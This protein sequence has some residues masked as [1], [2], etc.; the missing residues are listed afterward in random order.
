MQR[1]RRQAGRDGRGCPYLPRAAALRQVAGESQAEGQPLF[2]SSTAVVVA[3]R[4]SRAVVDRC[5]DVPRG[6]KS[7]L[8]HIIWFTCPRLYSMT[9][10]KIIWVS[11]GFRLQRVPFS[12]LNANQRLA[13][14]QRPEEGNDTLGPSRSPRPRSRRT[15]L[16]PL[17]SHPRTRYQD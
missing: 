17:G 8:L 3:I 10:E 6:L 5:V 15:T 12:R 1:L 7:L 11:L 9:L 13:A 4:R 14:L 16:P 2:G